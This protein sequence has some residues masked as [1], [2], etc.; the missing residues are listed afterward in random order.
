MSII[1][2]INAIKYLLITIGPK[3]KLW[4]EDEQ[5]GPVFVVLPSAFSFEG[6]NI[7]RNQK[8]NKVEQN[9]TEIKSL[10]LANIPQNESQGRTKEDQGKFT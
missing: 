1:I 2:L 4:E 5:D 8:K 6:N 7:E 9:K 3:R 10:K